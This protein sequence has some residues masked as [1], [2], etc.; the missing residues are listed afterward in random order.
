MKDLGEAAYIL[1]IKIIHDRS[2]RLIAL[3]QSAYLEKIIKKFRMENSKKGYT[4]MIE[5]PDYRKSQG[6]QTPNEVQHMQRIPYDL[7]IGLIMY[8]VRC[9]RPD[10]AFAQN[11]YMVLVYGAKSKAEL[12]VSCYVDAS[13]QTDKDDTKSQIRSRYID[14][15]EALIEA[16]WTGK[17]IDGLGGI[18]PSNKRHIEMLCDN[19]PAIAMANDPRILKGARHFQM[20]YHYIREVIQERKIVLKKVHTDDN[21][22]D[23]F[24]NL[25]PYNKHYEHA[26]AIGICHASSLM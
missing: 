1:R 8:A 2:K 9:T 11:L 14:V 24:T 15:V 4:P 19:E 25:M 26:R 21:I 18:V 3:S 5:K 13:F 22:A 16:V 10:V 7:A 17:F 23:P 20:K 12:K 6:A